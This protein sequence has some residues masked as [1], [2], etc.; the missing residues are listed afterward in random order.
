VGRGLLLTGPSGSG[1]SDLAFRLIERGAQLVSDD[2]VEI[3]ERGG[4]LTAAPP[5]AISGLLEVRGVGLVRVAVL[6]NVALAL[7]LAMTSRNQVPRLPEAGQWRLG[8]GVLPLYSLY[9][10]EISAAEKA[11]LLLRTLA[12]DILVD[13]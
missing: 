8:D 13:R 1:K 2:Q 3:V 11:E 5:P 6:P 10:F 12:E 9:P 4:H 7:V